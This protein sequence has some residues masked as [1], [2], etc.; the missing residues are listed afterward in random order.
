MLTEITSAVS[1]N[2]I[3]EYTSWNNPLQAFIADDNN[4]PDWV[5]D[6]FE[7]TAN[8]SENSIKVL[9]ARY[10]AHMVPSEP[11][12]RDQKDEDDKPL[13]CPF[14]ESISQ[15]YGR[16]AWAV[17]AGSFAKD[18]N[19]RLQ[20]ALRYW[21]IMVSQKF[22][23][24]SPTQVNAGIGGKGCLSA[25]FVVSPED[26]MGSIMEVATEAAMIE[27]W[28]G[29]IGFNF[30]K[31]RPRNDRIATTHGK[32][33]GP[34]SVMKLYAQVGATLTQ[35]AFRL[36]A[37]MATLD[38]WHPDI[39]DFI[40]CKDDDASLQNFN[41]SV[42]INATFME[43]VE[44]DGDWD[45]LNPRDG[46][47]VETINARD[48]WNEI[49]ESA[50]KTGDPGLI[51]VETVADAA[52][53]PHMGQCWPNP[54]GEQMLENHGSCNLGSINLTHYI[55]GEIIDWDA[56]EE[57]IRTSIRFLDSVVEINVFPLEVLRQT[58]LRT[59]R[60]GLGVM[61]W[62]DM[63]VKLGIAYD[64]DEAVGLADK[65]GEFFYEISVSESELMAEELGPFLEWDNSALKA[66]GLS[67]RR[68]SCLL[69]VAPTGTISRIA[70][71]GSGVEPFF[72]NAWWSNILWKNQ[73]SASQRMLDAPTAIWDA[74]RERLDDEE[75]VRS[76]LGQVADS[77]DDADVIFN[78]HG[79]DSSAFHTAMKISP[80]AHVLMQAAWQRWITNGV[81]KT[82][83][84]PNEATVEDI[85]ATYKLA[86]QTGCKGVTIY[87]DGSK[88]MQVLE[89]GSK[90]NEDVSALVEFVPAERPDT[91]YGLTENIPT[92]YGVMYV[93]VNFDAETNKPSEL[94]TAIGK[95]GGSEPA[96]LEGLSRMVSMNL[97][98]GF[99][100]ESIVNQLRGITSEPVK[101]KGM[102]IRSAEDG[103]AKV[104]LKHGRGPNT[105]LLPVADAP[106]YVSLNGS[107][108]NGL[109]VDEA[110]ACPK[111][112]S[113]MVMQEGCPRCLSCGHSKCG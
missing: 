105:P 71:C 91:M 111:C 32:A 21:A 68:N 49:L 89:T 97:R 95:A 67:P 109:V 47:V 39:R 96:H 63:L 87:R 36:G 54:C 35:G 70:D 93:T 11:C 15:L 80:A 44:A 27:K 94:F 61:G 74:L 24:N 72:A 73:E 110:M 82:V 107:S 45:L 66:K 29:G 99:P 104:L 77:P 18:E 100:V 69:S 58:N 55:K 60:I 38:A 26:D 10:C 86:F 75:Q 53:N 25:C 88:S 106:G 42:G 81:S 7:G 28:G 6:L 65:V 85:E 52:P 108:P 30:S 14:H 34:I 12:L 20:T 13:H 40:H 22:M 16:I 48:L 9:T 41:I 46:A 4:R 92:G 2:G 50:W 19:E 5:T 102:V 1:M 83:N 79:I 8:W 78:E 23:P 113:M 17:S 31:L 76:V 101:Y 112:P 3:S 59:R 43:A 103:I 90:D 84:L 64:S 37:H 56:L 62:A 57:D 33:C 98:Q 51:F